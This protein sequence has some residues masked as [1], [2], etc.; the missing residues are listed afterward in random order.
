MS[1]RNNPRR[2]SLLALLL[3]L[4]LFGNLSV[5]SAQQAT[6]TTGTVY[7]ST[8]TGFFVIVGGIGVVP[9]AGGAVSNT[10][11]VPAFTPQIA[12]SPNLTSAYVTTNGGGG[13]VLKLTPDGTVTTFATLPFS[14]FAVGTH[15]DGRV[16][17]AG[18]NGNNVYDI[19]AGGAGPF[20]LYATIPVFDDEG[21]QNY[22]MLRTSAGRLLLSG[23]YPQIYDIT[24]PA[25]VTVAADASGLPGDLSNFKDLAEGP[26]GEIYAWAD[27]GRAV[28][29][30][31]G[32]VPSIFAT[33]PFHSSSGSVAYGYGK[34]LVGGRIS[35]SPFTRVIYDISAGGNFPTA[36]APFATH[37]NGT[38]S[39][40]L[41]DTVPAL[42]PSSPQSQLAALIAQV[43]AL[44]TA[45]VLTPNQG[46]ALVNKLEHTIDK[47]DKEQTT[48]ACGQ[49]GSFVNQVNAF[50]NNGSLTPA[51][52]Q[53][54]IN[55]ATAVQTSLGC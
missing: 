6:F 46:N 53:A 18:L 48:A 45:G 28:I 52:G 34:L 49:L 9:S 36:P 12:W 26:S 54:L 33:L 55:A 17:V 4:A 31:T 2:F 19:S 13:S 16:L 15:P 30:V 11:S 1:Y 50:V 20:P 43:Q 51:Q 23:S 44:A 29:K 38:L 37:G 7:S 32:G 47:L 27:E 3:T 35:S 8:G 21:D 41:L 5:T 22:A 14:A 40:L 24:D 10:F 42:Y 25:N 39:Q